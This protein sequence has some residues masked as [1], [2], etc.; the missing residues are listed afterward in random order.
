MFKKGD[1]VEV[2]FRQNGQPITKPGIVEK[3]GSAAVGKIVLDT[4]GYVSRVNFAHVTRSNIPLPDHMVNNYKKGDRVKITTDKEGTRYG[5]VDSPGKGY[6]GKITLDGGE[7]YLSDIPLGLVKKSDEPLPADDPDLMAD[8]SIKKYQEY[9]RM[10]EETIAYNA[11]IHFQGRLA[12][13]AKNDGQGG[14]D[15]FDAKFGG[16]KTQDLFTAACQEWAAAYSSEKQ[17]E[18]E[19]VW[20]RYYQEHKPYGVTSKAFFEEEDRQMKEICAESGT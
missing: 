13:Y 20:V 10:S 12:L 15:H 14:P 16:R 19:A 8:W 1:R 4:G 7:L 5:I 2:A 17:F 3:G 6:V 9:P 18:I 11:H